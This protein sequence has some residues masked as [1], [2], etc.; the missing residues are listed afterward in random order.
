MHPALAQDGTVAF[1]PGDIFLLCTDGL[2]DS[3]ILQ[4]LRT[5]DATESLENPAA[6]LVS[7]SLERSG[8]DNTNALYLD[9]P[10]V[11]AAVFITTRTSFFSPGLIIPS[12]CVNGSQ[13]S[14][15][16]VNVT[17]SHAGKR[18]SPLLWSGK[19]N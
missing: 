10:P 4:R 12:S 18:A 17:R 8:R 15:V 1:E 3:Q 9:P 14:A 19:F 13:P 6:R 2:Y 5:P 11:A 7:D 16:M